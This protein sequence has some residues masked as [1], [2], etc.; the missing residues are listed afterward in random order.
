M[1]VARYE[2]DDAFEYYQ[3]Q[4]AGLG[5]EFIKEAMATIN[6][7]RIN[8]HAWAILTE[9]TRR[10]LFNR[11]P[12]GIIYQVRENEI[13]IIAIANLHREPDYWTSRMNR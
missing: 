9:R 2:L 8:P 3:K 5:D 4:K 1:D 6:R 11:F 13:L 7:I 12:Y 10:C